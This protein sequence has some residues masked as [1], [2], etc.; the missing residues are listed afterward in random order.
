MNNCSK[1]EFI[2]LFTDY[3]N[4]RLNI[5]FEYKNYKKNGVDKNISNNIFNDVLKNKA[6]K[7]YIFYNELIEWNRKINLTSITDPKDFIEKHVIDSLMLLKLLKQNY[8]I[9]INKDFKDGINIIDYKDNETEDNKIK[10]MDIGSGGG[11]PGIMLKIFNPEIDLISVE[12]IQK[13]CNFQKYIAGKFNFKNFDCINRNIYELKELPLVNAITTRAAFNLKELIKLIDK[14]KLNN[15]NKNLPVDLF[16][17][18]TKYSEA[19]TI[20]KQ[21]FNDKILYIDKFLMY[22]NNYNNNKDTNNEF[23]LIA[24]FKIKYIN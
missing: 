24:N 14:I 21:E 8:N 3:I 1:N 9:N 18:L 16:F 19:L 11:F 17:F 7:Y 2:S 15:A 20:E 13:K 12:S 23:K 22:K 6:E 4:N 5:Y 10:L